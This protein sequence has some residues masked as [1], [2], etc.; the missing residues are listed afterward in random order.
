MENGPLIVSFPISNG[1]FPARYVSL[2]EALYVLAI[3]FG[4]E[5]L[6]TFGPLGFH[7]FFSGIFTCAGSVGDLPAD[8]RAL[9]L[10]PRASQQAGFL[11]MKVPNNGGV[12]T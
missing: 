7:R 9:Q 11:A 5:T 4:S 12:M 6:Q 1:D 8:I 2:L 3:F 10:Q